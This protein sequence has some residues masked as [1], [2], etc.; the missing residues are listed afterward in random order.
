MIRR[1]KVCNPKLLVLVF[2]SLLMTGCTDQIGEE[3]GSQSIALQETDWNSA[4]SGKTSGPIQFR[5]R[6]EEH[7]GRLFKLRVF[8]RSALGDLEGWN[9]DVTESGLKL[10]DGTTAVL[11]GNS[12]DSLPMVSRQF[13]FRDEASEFDDIAVK[14]EVVIGNQLASKNFKVKLGPDSETAVEICG[15]AGS[16]CER[17]VPAVMDI[18]VGRK[19]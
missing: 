8:A 9:I 14:V 18:G 11:K 19:R 13:E 15:G 16:S 5:Y 4:I 12:A 2:M 3:V 10:A 17:T 6:L 7:E 1:P